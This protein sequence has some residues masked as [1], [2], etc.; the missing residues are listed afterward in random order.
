MAERAVVVPKTKVVTIGEDAAN[1][2]AIEIDACM[3]ET[4]SATNTITK[5]PVEKK[6][7]MADHIRPE[8]DTVTLN[9]FVSN[10]PLSREQKLR[11]VKSMG[12]EFQTTAAAEARPQDIGSF[13]GRGAQT[14]QKLMKLRE[15]GALV[16]VITTLKTYGV[17]ATEGLAIQSI[18]V[19][20]NRQNYDGLEFTITFELIRIVRNKQTQQVETRRP[21][22]QPK[23]KT[24]AQV[25][26]STERKKTAALRLTEQ[27]GI[28]DDMA[29]SAN[30]TISSLGG[31]ILQSR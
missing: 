1:S 4:H 8:T 27:S 11:S 7:D 13:E 12:V 2:S 31:S 6:R 19:P 15:S 16:K 29:K 10:T 17:T 30:P 25:P 20:R 5:H 21:A 18:S 26:Q 9:C 14:Y 28:A 23:V 24:G 3:E 22:R